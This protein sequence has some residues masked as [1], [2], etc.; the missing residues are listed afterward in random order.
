M[1]EERWLKGN[2][3]FSMLRYL[4]GNADERKIR[5]FAC[6]WVRHLWDFLQDPRSQQ[7]VEIAERYADG[8]VSRKELSAASTQA[9]RAKEEAFQANNEA[10]RADNGKEIKE[11]ALK[12]P[13]AYFGFQAARSAWEAARPA[14][15]PAFLS[16]GITRPVRSGTGY[17]LT[18]FTV[19]DRAQ[20]A[21]LADVFGNPFRPI[22]PEA[23][24]R[25]PAVVD[26]ARAA[27]EERILP[28]G[29]LDATRLAILADA[30]EEAG[31]TEPAILEHLRGPGPHVRGC[32]VVDCL[33]GTK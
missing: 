4:R 10:Y 17:Y 33:L 28:S 11:S 3:P 25:T 18:T 29:L 6:A 9:Q 19:Y 16:A 14:C 5:L 8:E 32:F 12:W 27:Y 1:N 26:L 13:K 23:A 2:S 22:A 31:C 20:A 21:L 24:P 7:A 30:L 15:R